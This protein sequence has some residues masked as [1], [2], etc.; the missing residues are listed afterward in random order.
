VPTLVVCP[1]RDAL[2]RPAA[3]RELARRIG[4]ARL[5]SFDAAGHGVIFQCAP[6]L[7]QHLAAHFLGHLV[8]GDSA[9]TR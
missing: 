4:G 5:V 9:K 2:V 8:A 3:C 6:V 7:N 1:E